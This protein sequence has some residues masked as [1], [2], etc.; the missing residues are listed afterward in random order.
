MIVVSGMIEID[1]ADVETA[2]KAILTMM[3]ETAKEDGCIIY[4]F[5]QDVEF[6]AQF[7]MYEEWQTKDALKVHSASDHMKDFIAAL[8]NLK[9]VSRD[10]KMFEAGESRAL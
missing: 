5:A 10:V 1:G 6:P 7:R 4:R 9:L 2:K 3:H 8:G